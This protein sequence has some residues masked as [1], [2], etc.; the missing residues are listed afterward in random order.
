LAGTNFCA[1]NLATYGPTNNS[2]FFTNPIR[3]KSKSI[4]SGKLAS[5]RHFCHQLTSDGSSAIL[6]DMDMTQ[7]ADFLPQAPNYNEISRIST[8]FEIKSKQKTVLGIATLSRP[9]FA[10]PQQP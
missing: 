7:P 3:Q 5:S 6:S 2:L 10:S 8:A 9:T 4:P 1:E